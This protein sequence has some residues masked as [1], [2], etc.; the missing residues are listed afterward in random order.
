MQC[1]LTN[2]SGGHVSFSM[3]V[4]LLLSGR[5]ALAGPDNSYEAR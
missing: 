2:E 4:N 3:N 5:N 1:N